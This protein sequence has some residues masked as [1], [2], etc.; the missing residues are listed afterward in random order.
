MAEMTGKSGKV[1]VANVTAQNHT[2]NFSIPDSRKP[3]SITIPMG[4]QKFVG[5]M[6]APAIDAMLDQLGPYGLVELGQELKRE[7]VTYIFNVGSPIPASAIQKLYDRNRGILT[8][9]GKKRRIENAV[10]A[11]A[12]MNTEETPLNNF[13]ADVEEVDSGDLGGDSDNVAEGVK[14]DNT[15]AESNENRKPRGSRKRGG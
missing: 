2:I 6:A 12:V 4:S 13:T 7:K 15:A 9:E 14:I 1:Y 8:D 5:E 10:A 3:M 11:N